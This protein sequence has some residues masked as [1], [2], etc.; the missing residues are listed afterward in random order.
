MPREARMAASDAAAMPFPSEETTPPVTN[1]N[2]VMGDKFWKF[3]VYTNCS[4]DTNACSTAWNNGSPL[5]RRR[6][7]GQRP[8]QSFAGTLAPHER[9]HRIDCR[10]LR[11]PGD[12][13]THR[14][15]DLRRLEVVLCG[16]G[17]DRRPDRFARPV[18]GFKPSREI[19]QSRA[20]RR[21][22]LGGK[23]LLYRFNPRC[24]AIEILGLPGHL[25]ERLSSVAQQ[26]SD[27]G[28]ARSA[29]QINARDELE[30][31]AEMPG[32]VLGRK[33]LDVLLIPPL[34]FFEIEARRRWMHMRDVEPLDELLAGEDLVGAVR[35]AAARER[36]D[37]S[38]EH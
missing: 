20:H 2:L 27:I 4:C 38:E 18:D 10:C 36:V 14:H 11:R 3:A 1:T 28:Q 29:R 30:K 34:E 15:H 8:L 26:D 9:E 16:N 12:K 31:R 19:R 35:P 5:D 23:F 7:L 32:K 24:L 13:R 6:R 21:I 37:R 22:Q 17:L 25:R 33:P